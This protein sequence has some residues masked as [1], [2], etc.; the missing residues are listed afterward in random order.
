MIWSFVS[1]INFI[2]IIAILLLSISFHEYS[3]GFAATILGDPTPRLSGRLTLNPFAHID[4]LGTFIVP[5]L[6]FVLSAGAFSFGYA[7]PVPVNPYHFRN[8]KKDILWVGLAGPAVN[9]I[10]ALVLI[11]ILKFTNY[12][13]MPEV[14]VSGIIINLVIGILNLVPI[15]PL[16]GS[17][18]LSALLPYKF[19][20]M[21]LKSEKIGSLLIVFL[22]VTGFFR[23]FILPIMS[24]IF[25]SFKI[26]VTL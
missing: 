4:I 18:I 14:L 10:I 16:D 9:F 2:F 7:K 5:I 20:Y 12:S 17:K 23:G 3:H 1:I 22:I 6:L 26:N 11:V 19:S 13:F 25:S 15:P 8:P 24:F 21:Y